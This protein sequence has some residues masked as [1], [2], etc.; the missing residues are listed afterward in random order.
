M[1]TLGPYLLANLVSF[2]L[3]K[4]IQPSGLDRPPILALSGTSR[5]RQTDPRHMFFCLLDAP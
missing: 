2:R 1:N 3:Y 5:G 4:R